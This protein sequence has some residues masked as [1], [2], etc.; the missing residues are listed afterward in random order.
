MC[1][2]FGEIDRNQGMDSQELVKKN[3]CHKFHYNLA[4][5]LCME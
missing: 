3:I 2:W 1:S 4:E 5:V